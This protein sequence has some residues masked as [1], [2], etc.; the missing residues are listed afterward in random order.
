MRHHKLFAVCLS[1]IFTQ[2]LYAQNFRTVEPQKD[3]VLI[4]HENGEEL[5][6]T[7]YLGGDAYSASMMWRSGR[8]DWQIGRDYLGSVKQIVAPDGAL[9]GD[10][11]YDPWGRLRNKVTFKAYERGKEPELFIGRGYTGHE[12]LPQFGLINMNAR[13]YDPL[14]GRFLSP[15]PYV[16]VSDF[17]QNFNRYSY[18]LNN[19]LKYTDEDGEWIVLTTMVWTPITLITGYLVPLITSVSNPNMAKSQF[20]QAWTKYGQVLGNAAKIDAGW[21]RSDPHKNF[22]GRA[23]EV[24]SHFTWQFT[25]E[26]IGNTMQGGWNLLGGIKSVGSYGG[27]T[28]AQTYKEEWGAVTLGSY[29]TGCRDISASPKNVLFQHEYGHYLQSQKSGIAYL[30]RYGI[31]SLFS[32]DPHDNHPV[33]QDANIRAFNYFM[34][35]ESG[36]TPSD[37]KEKLLE[38]EEYGWSNPF[39]GYSLD[40]PSDVA[41]LLTLSNGIVNPSP[42]DYL[43]SITLVGV[44]ISGLINSSRDKTKY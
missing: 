24:V 16:Q 33:E 23:G 40:N 44:I 5:S 39:V 42:W 1:T 11:S 12:H 37:W 31:P 41:A 29:I 28:V 21:F 8:S 34:N 27:A 19:P 38:N 20:K 7:L 3:S 9:I 4:R 2:A 26:T 32:K 18:A 30:T 14:L 25:Q 43:S 17:T 10:Y 36:F 35:N 15:D 6:E 22:W 13:L